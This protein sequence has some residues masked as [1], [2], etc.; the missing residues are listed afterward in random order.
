[1]DKDKDTTAKFLTTTSWSH[2][3]S[4]FDDTISPKDTSCILI[5]AGFGADNRKALDA[6]HEAKV[7]MWKA[8]SLTH[9]EGMELL[10]PVQIDP[11]FLK[12]HDYTLTHQIP[13]TVLSCG[14]DFIIQEYLTWYLGD[15]AASVTIMANYGKHEIPFVAFDTFDKVTAIVQGLSERLLN[16]A[17]ASRQLV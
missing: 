13:L 7:L 8:V 10:R 15:E 11:G 5:D 17:E 2:V 16:M 12:F 6:T 3:F 1:M 4:D 14:L 9:T